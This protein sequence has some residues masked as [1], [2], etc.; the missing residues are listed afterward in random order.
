M[1]KT[2]A[3]LEHKIG[4]RIYH[5]IC[6]HDA[7]LGEIHDALHNMK[8]FVVKKINEVHNAAKPEE[9]PKE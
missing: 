9:K 7:P 1:L 4:D 5:F 6:D 3:K 8:E 2:I